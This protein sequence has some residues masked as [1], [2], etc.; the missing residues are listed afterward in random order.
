MKKLF[1]EFPP[2]P[3]PDWEREI[4]RDLKGKDVST[5]DWR[6]YEGFAVKPFYTA[7]DMDDL[8]Y[9]ADALPGEFPYVRGVEGGR[10]PWRIDERITAPTPAEANGL[11]REAIANGA[12]SL[13]FVCEVRDGAIYGI[14]LRTASDMS[15]LLKE[16]PLEG[17]AVNFRA[18]DGAAAVLALLLIE[19][20][21]RGADVSKLAG[22]VEADPVG[23]FAL[24][25]RFPGG[26]DESFRGLGVL[27]SYAAEHA[28]SFK[29]ILA[30]GGVFHD[31]G[32]SA[33]EELAFTL[34]SGVEYMSRLT[35]GGLSPDTIAAQMKFSFSVGSN[36]FMEIAKLRAARLL[37]AEI[38][39]RYE[40]AHEESKK[41][42][43]EARTSSWN[44]T[45][46]DPYVN[47]LRG[48]VEAM[49]A[50]I[51]G[52][53]AVSVLPLDSA[54]K[55][56]GEFTLRMAR[57]TQ[58][59]LK[60]ESYLDRVKDP[61]SGSYYIE[62]LT[63]SIAGASLELFLEVEK[64]GGFVAAFKNGFIQDRISKTRAERDAR[65]AARADVFVGVNQYPN[66]TEKEPDITGPV[67]EAALKR[68]K[69]PGGPFSSVAELKERLSQKGATLGDAVPA[70]DSE[71]AAT[72]L[73]PY[74]GAAAFE[75]LRLKTIEYAKKTGETPAVYLLPVGSVSMRNA[76][77]AF[78]ANFFGC[79]G[80]SVVEGEP[81]ETAQSSAEDALRSGVKII[82]ICSSDAEYPEVA[83]EICELVKKEKPGACIVV[84]GNPREH[85][86]ELRAAGVDDFIHARSN[87]VKALE[88]FQRL[89]G[90]DSER[91]DRS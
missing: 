88:K 9:L 8:E 27:T 23:R 84:A 44:K 16:I 87:A 73:T 51:G 48:T 67:S 38:M 59:I 25:G 54:Y 68:G 69:K 85:I 65:I 49:A 32:A 3:P 64:Q 4:A 50:S 17:T 46:F 52:G 43:I 55:Q 33:I 60:H 62:K 63:D 40:P 15:K 18:G 81:H 47:L 41:M 11:A 83:P 91:G 10:N 90:M 22:S 56:P 7:D 14:P 5:L 86:D 53:E 61:A 2:V 75:S 20:E 80:F 71:P 58:L 6:P 66:T 34:A 74:R 79:A 1:E 76:R 42:K 13:T 30:G 19:A 36:Y 57:N 37:W 72:P 35:S 45:V 89:L 29:A 12:D 28:P 24:T 21:K 26:E 70:G 82:V 77:A 31:S 78:S 39:D